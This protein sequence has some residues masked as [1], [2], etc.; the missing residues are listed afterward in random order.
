M[1]VNC[2][3][4]IPVGNGSF[5]ADSLT[6]KRFKRNM[7]H[8]NPSWFEADSISMELEFFSIDKT[9]QNSHTIRIYRDD[10]TQQDTVSLPAGNRS[11]GRQRATG[12]S[13]DMVT[14]RNYYLSMP[15]DEGDVLGPC[16]QCFVVVVLTN[17]TKLAIPFNLMDFYSAPSNH[18]ADWGQTPELISSPGST[19]PSQVSAGNFVLWKKDKDFWHGNAVI[20]GWTLDCNLGG[21]VDP[22][23]TRAALFNSN[24]G[25]VAGSE[26]GPTTNT[27][28]DVQA[29][30]AD[31]ADDAENFTDGESFEVKY[32]NGGAADM[33]LYSARLWMRLS[34]VEGVRIPIPFRQPPAV[35][36]PDVTDGRFLYTASRWGDGVAADQVAYLRSI[37]YKNAG[38][39]K[40]KV[41]VRVDNGWNDMDSGGNVWFKATAEV[42]PAVGSENRGDVQLSSALNGTTPMEDG[43]RYA[44]E[45]TDGDN[46]FTPSL[47]IV[48]E[49]GDQTQPQEP[50]SQKT[51]SSKGVQIGDFVLTGD[52]EI[53]A[54][55]K[56]TESS[57]NARKSEAIEGGTA[58]TLTPTKIQALT[59]KK[60]GT[61]AIHFY[62]DQY[63]GSASDDGYLTLQDRPGFA[64]GT[65]DFT[66]EFWWKTGN[67]MDSKKIQTFL[68]YHTDNDH[69]WIMAWRGP[70]HDG[71]ALDFR[72]E[73]SSGNWTN[74]INKAWQPEDNTWYH[75]ALVRNGNAW[76]FFVDGVSKGTAT[77]SISLADYNTMWFGREG[78][79]SDG[80][81]IDA[82]VGEFDEIRISNVAR[83]TSEFTPPDA[84]FT[85]DEDTLS[86][87][88]GDGSTV[89]DEVQNGG[90]PYTVTL[91]QRVRATDHDGLEEKFGSGALFWTRGSEA[92]PSTAGLEID[93]YT[94]P[95]TGDFTWECWWKTPTSFSGLA[96]GINKFPIF[97]HAN[98]TS[99]R[100]HWFFDRSGASPVLRV[101]RYEGS[102]NWL[103]EVNWT[104]ATDTWYHLAVCRSG[105]STRMFVNGN[106]VGSTSTN[107]VDLPQ[108][109]Q[110]FWARGIVSGS[111]GVGSFDEIR[112]SSNARYTSNFTPPT[113]PF[114]MDPNTQVLIHGDLNYEAEEQS[115]EVSKSSEQVLGHDSFYSSDTLGP[116]LAWADQDDWQL[117]GGSGDFTIECYVRFNAWNG[118][119]ENYFW[120][121]RQDSGNWWG[122]MYD[123]SAD[124]WHFYVDGVSIISK[125][126]AGV[127]LDTWYHFA[128]TRSVNTWRMYIDGNKV[129]EVVSAQS[130]GDYSGLLRLFHLDG[131]GGDY[132][133]DGWITQARIINGTARYTSDSFTPEEIDTSAG[134]VSQNTS[135]P[136]TGDG[137]IVFDGASY[138]EVTPSPS[139][140]FQFDGD[141]V[142]ML[143][144]KTEGDGALITNWTAG[145]LGWELV[146]EDGVAVFRAST[147]GTTTAF[148]LTGTTNIAD[149]EWHH[150][151]V[152]RTGDNTVTLYI[153]GI[154]ED[155]GTFAGTTNNTGANAVLVGAEDADD[156]G[157]FLIGEV[158]EVHIINGGD[159][160][161]TGNFTPSTSVSVRCGITNEAGPCPGSGGTTVLLLQGDEEPF[162]DTPDGEVRRRRM[163]FMIENMVRKTPP[164]PIVTGGD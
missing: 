101:G 62:G 121:Q 157:N 26:V 12:L 95:G 107:S 33:A 16:L 153:D 123:S 100:W 98:S 5:K 111:P 108:K 21:D 145:D 35:E 91:N 129:A 37:G 14:A 30:Q 43:R 162:I 19:S 122:C 118:N 84:A 22:G 109:S 44:V 63:T 149:G 110:T 104:P 1:G 76:E 67:D 131:A 80:T 2:E 42:T 161:I 18:T 27:G 158:D 20:D 99:S 116:G 144:C 155:S 53:D 32:W 60:F 68:S 154:A 8:F 134:S 51:V 39:G 11:Y 128:V 138:I 141:F 150:V 133:I 102:Y 77:N 143:W 45:I 34:L 89:T 127:S 93:G 152:V 28:T 41:A 71:P 31:F 115:G 74:V 36:Q 55:D 88:H 48:M 82:L 119:D 114:E 3:V 7:F 78:N 142:I 72:V 151:A 64:L 38:T 61:G 137:S 17:A 112:I 81:Q 139:T 75:I 15:A 136:K 103:I 86:L 96:A 6:T 46:L 147:D 47:E 105:G 146:I 50:G 23:G 73:V 57:V 117:G 106:Q 90:S 70:A 4:Y 52:E 83:Y 59:T 135:T 94:A 140:D 25:K 85:V 160:G 65:G 156:P 58:V 97:T 159:G 29:F 49:V 10:G 120:T 9:A 164:T 124:A 92:P 56:V 126:S 66:V 130:I 87:I 132:G 69:R 24:G 125:T 113:E 163:A 40:Y 79:L 148:E 13:L 54:E